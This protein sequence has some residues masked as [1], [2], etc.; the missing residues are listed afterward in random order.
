MA[1]PSPSCPLRYVLNRQYDERINVQRRLLKERLNK[2]TNLYRKDLLAHYG[3]VNAIEF[4]NSGKFLVSGGDDRRVLIWNV[5]HAIHSIGTPSV[6]RAN[7]ISNIF[8]LAFDSTTSRVFSAGNDDQ[9]IVHDAA[10]GD[11][12]DFFLHEQPVYGLSIDPLNDYVFASACDDGRILIY[13]IREAPGTEP[14]CLAR[15]NSAF[16]AVMFNPVEPRILTTANSKEGVGLWDVRKPCQILM[17][18]GGNNPSQSCMSVRFNQAGNQIL[19]LRRRLPPVLYSVHSSVHI[20][21][22]DHPGYYNSCTMKSCSF[23]GDDDQ[24]VLSGSDDFNLYM[25]KIPSTAEED[26]WVDT[27]HMIL[28]GHR[29]IVNQVRFHPTNCIIASSGVEKLIKFW[30]PYPLPDSVGSL[31][32]GCQVGGKQRKVFTHEEYINL[33]LRTGQFM[34]HDYSHQSTKEDPRMMA[35][36]DSLVQREIEGWISDEIHSSDVST[37]AYA[38]ASSQSDSESA[39]TGS[40]VNNLENNESEPQEAQNRISQLIARKRSQLLRHAKSQNSEETSRLKK[41]GRHHGR[42]MN[43][44]H[45]P[46]GGFVSDTSDSEASVA[47]KRL[48][49]TENDEKYR[50]KYSKG[51][52]SRKNGSLFHNTKYKISVS[53]A[54][55]KREL[56][57]NCDIRKHRLKY[58]IAYSDSSDDNNNNNNNN[59]DDD[60]DDDIDDDDDDDDNND[61]DKRENN[62][63]NDNDDGD[64][65]EYEG[66]WQPR[67]KVWTK[68][69]KRTK[70]SSSL[71]NQKCDSTSKKTITAVPSE[72]S[73]SSVQFSDISSNRI[74]KFYRKRRKLHGEK[75][76]KINFDIL[77]TSSSGDPDTGNFDPLMS[78]CD[79]KSECSKNESLEQESS[80]NI[81]N[82][83]QDST[84]DSNF[85]DEQKDNSVSLVSEADLTGK[86]KV[87]TSK[88]NGALISV[89]V[90]Y[91][92]CFEPT[93][94]N[95]SKSEV[96]NV[97]LNKNYSGSSAASNL[98]S[99]NASV[100]STP[101]GKQSNHST[102]EYETPDSGIILKECTSTGSATSVQDVS[103]PSCSSNDSV[104]GQ[105]ASQSTGS[106]IAD[107][108][109]FKKFRIK[110]RDRIRRNFRSRRDDS[111]SP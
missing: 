106:R 90:P 26:Q 23:A 28:H 65:D 102:E 34:T 53:K 68:T 16:H 59:D 22:F 33:V 88:T 13:D 9:V 1:R 6:M 80:G 71:E 21:Q 35:F 94:V 109:V 62:V 89:S 83:S 56:K 44:F 60:D 55:S 61:V 93:G 95:C 8:C 84:F 27:A 69:V 15:Y 41:S 7:H 77:E 73:T 57:N 36:F 98:A 70:K 40:P 66:T 74:R 72:A 29:S 100:Y 79:R 32:E 52:D 104:P 101:N 76:R 47:T 108:T 46:P 51:I 39:F 54:K 30:S 97:N 18:F 99:E 20:C 42:F 78:S 111:E 85:E 105:E 5:E 38:V 63:D 96:S 110:N 2:A 14:F 12:L 103:Q 82:H 81:V 31:V 10:T 67:R 3:C 19:A 75:K 91:G 49:T 45:T 58:M 11:P 17:R 37:T 25:W 92:R 24:Y 86:Q 50:K 87:P 64:D 107:W 43:T 48:R 4:S